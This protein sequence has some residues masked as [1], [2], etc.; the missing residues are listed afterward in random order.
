MYKLFVQYNT[1][2]QKFSDTQTDQYALQEPVKLKT[3]N[4]VHTEENINMT[5]PFTNHKPVLCR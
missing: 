1:I 4:A 5:I 3:E 2:Q